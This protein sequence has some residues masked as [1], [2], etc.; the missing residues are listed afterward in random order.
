MRKVC[1]LF[2][3]ILCLLVSFAY[4]EHD[5]DHDQHMTVQQSYLSFNSSGM[6][7]AHENILQNISIGETAGN[8][9]FTTD[10][11]MNGIAACERGVYIILPTDQSNDVFLLSTEREMHYQFS[12]PYGKIRTMFATSE[13]L[14][15]LYEPN[16]E[17]ESE[18]DFEG[19]MELYSYEG[20][21]KSLAINK[22]LNIATTDT[23]SLYVTTFN[24][25]EARLIKLDVQ[26]NLFEIVLEGAMVAALP[27]TEQIYCIAANDRLYQY[28]LPHSINQF[29]R[30]DAN[31]FAPP[32]LVTVDGFLYV[33]ASG[34]LNVYEKSA[35]GKIDSANELVLVNCTDIGD[36]RLTNAID[37]FEMKYPEKKVIMVE[38]ERDLLLTEL[39]AGE[40]QYDIL[41]IDSAS[42]D[43]YK[44]TGVTIDL[45]EH[46]NLMQMFDDWIPVTRAAE[47]DRKLACVPA[48][49][50]APLLYVNT[51]LKP[52]LK[53]EIPFETS[54]ESFFSLAQHFD[55]DTN[56]DGVADAKFL[57]ENLYYPDFIYQFVSANQ[58]NEKIDFSSPVFI[59]VLEM[60][61]DLVK[62]GFV[63]DMFGDDN[64]EAALFIAGRSLEPETNEFI[65]LPKFEDSGVYIPA[66][67]HGLGISRFSTKLDYAVEFLMMYASIDNQIPPVGFGFIK[68]VSL[69]PEMKNLTGT[70]AEQIVKYTE[71]FEKVSPAWINTEFAIYV[72]EVLE[73]YLS[74]DLTVNDVVDMLNQK[75][76]MIR[77]G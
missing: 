63:V 38:R 19:V 33:L 41:F 47:F 13:G 26:N 6:W 74:D 50:S 46:D 2:L 48:Y 55:T 36:F 66:Y 68:D 27:L 8:T 4:A 61:K 70:Q 20:H 54:W 62:E 40:S 51:T 7:F 3:V 67:V 49:V 53:T 56:D 76:E 11:T 44:A 31:E 17:G 65:S 32:C 15:I 35:I 43:N 58:K 71:Y 16:F 37:K 12:I 21:K 39:M 10:V 14:V 34:E 42:L 24:D 59:R 18:L 28:E 9:F 1:I 69:Y 52:F 29:A 30:V 72:T 57:A 23:N 77:M 45:A 5:H 60:Y 22:A 25:F 75:V 73:K 64:S